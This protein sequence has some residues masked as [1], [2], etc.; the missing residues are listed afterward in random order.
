MFP[1]QALASYLTT[2]RDGEPAPFST[3]EAITDE[4][5][6]SWLNN[7]SKEELVQ[8]KAATN[9]TAC[10]GTIG[11]NGALYTPSGWY[12]FEKASRGQVAS[13]DS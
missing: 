5:C 10:Y 12:V 2:G 7:I 6:K 8:L 3:K 1:Y 13:H 11:P 4:Y 9:D